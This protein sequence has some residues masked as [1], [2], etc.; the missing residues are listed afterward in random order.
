ML[1][2]ENG[3]LSETE[4]GRTLREKTEIKKRRAENKKLQ[5]WFWTV[6]LLSKEK[7]AGLSIRQCF[8][9]RVKTQ[10]R[11]FPY[12]NHVTVF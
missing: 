4:E 6:C 1:E 8:K 12:D 7:K 11:V 10:H 5:Y 3:R 9:K 2:V